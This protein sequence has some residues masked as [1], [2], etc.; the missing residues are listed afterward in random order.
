MIAEEDDCKICTQL[1]PITENRSGSIRNA[2]D[3]ET[4]NSATL[5]PKHIV[6]AF[7]N[8]LTALFT[9]AMRKSSIC[10]PSG[11]P[12]MVKL[13][14][15]SPCLVKPRACVTSPKNNN[16]ISPGS[17]RTVY[18]TNVV[19]RTGRLRLNLSRS[20]WRSRCSLP[21]NPPVSCHNRKYNLFSHSGNLQP[22]SDS[23]ANLPHTQ[24]VNRSPHAKITGSCCYEPA[25]DD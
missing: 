22:V 12:S 16:R 7:V 13:F 1:L 20:N 14:T 19:R 4:H 25:P 11:T 18:S 8:R 15:A 24:G 9:G 10:L 21:H 17:S 5:T 3:A 23:T 2:Y 6:D